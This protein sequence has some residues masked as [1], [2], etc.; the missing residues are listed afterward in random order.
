M[1]TRR[2]MV[3]CSGLICPAVNRV[4]LN[5]PASTE[6]AEYHKCFLSFRNTTDLS[7]DTN[8]L[9][10]RLHDRLGN[11]MFQLASLYALARDN[12]MTPM[13]L[14]YKDL[15]I[16]FPQINVALSP[17]GH[18]EQHW[19][20]QYEQGAMKYRK[21][22]NDMFSKNTSIFLSGYLQ[23]WRYFHHRENELRSQFVFNK[24]LQKD[25][26]TFLHAAAQ[27]WRSLRAKKIKESYFVETISP[28][29]TAPHFIGLH[30]RR[31]D[32]IEE[33]FSSLGYK[34][35]EHTYFTRAMQHMANLLENVVFVVVSDDMVWIKANVTSDRY[36][37]VDSYFTK[38]NQD[39]CL[40]AVVTT[41]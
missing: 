24:T 18:P 26:D 11:H 21:Q 19:P 25:V 1:S 3:I 17:E 13:A 5:K 35:T 31:G 27:A 10:T 15:L 14:Y 4:L 9:A 2:T 12:S 22:L 37:G 38:A 7:V 28:S 16:C 6:P 8:I 39:I 40:W 36:I 32:F 23:S 34:A 20:H 30:V 33:Y 41:P 29:S